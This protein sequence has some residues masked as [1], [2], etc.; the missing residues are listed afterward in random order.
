ME[1]RGLGTPEILVLVTVFLL[2]VGA[3][4]MLIVALVLL[5]NRRKNSNTGMKKCAFCGYSI[6]AEATD[7][8]FCGR[9]LAS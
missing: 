3:P 4:I 5:F 8:R 2:V 6:Q 9:E 7:C 1:I